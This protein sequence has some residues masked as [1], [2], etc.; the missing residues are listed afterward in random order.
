MPPSFPDPLCF[1]LAALALL[2]FQLHV[3][4][5]VTQPHGHK[6]P[7]CACEPSVQ[8]GNELGEGEKGVIKGGEQGLLVGGEGPQGMEGA[9]WG[10]VCGVQGCAKN[11]VAGEKK[12]DPSFLA[13]TNTPGCHRPSARVYPG[14]GVLNG[15]MEGCC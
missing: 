15:G 9:R 5:M 14:S 4:A 12:V 6:T 8:C 1:T 10:G 7:E 13:A 11:E 2:Q 3:L